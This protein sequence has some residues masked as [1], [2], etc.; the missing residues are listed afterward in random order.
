M[1]ASD[2]PAL[3]LSPTPFHEELDGVTFERL[4]FR[5]GTSTA[6]YTP[7]PEWTGFHAPPAFELHPPDD[8]RVVARIEFDDA[9]S[10]VIPFDEAGLARLRTEAL[11]RV[12]EGAVEARIEAEERS[13]FRVAG[14][15]TLLL[16][17]SY[18]LR[19]QKFRQAVV[20]VNLS[21]RRLRFS[22][23]AP[24][25]GFDAPFAAFRQSLFSWYWVPAEPAD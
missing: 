3:S 6:V 20:Y 5:D 24:E 12:P 16:T 13:P 18:E 7:P 25:S 1:A 4:G 8:A 21:K 14:H 17:L 19:G 11:T 9:V 22:C 23:R 10:A 2:V 15:E